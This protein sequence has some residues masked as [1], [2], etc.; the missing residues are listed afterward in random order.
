[1]PYPEPSDPDYCEGSREL[2]KDFD[3]D[4]LWHRCPH[5]KRP[6]AAM[7]KTRRFFPH[8]NN[9]KRARKRDSVHEG[10][11]EFGM[12]SRRRMYGEPVAPVYAEPER[13]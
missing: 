9:I 6:I 4:K 7:G 13:V 2:I 5:C 12:N 3:P 8:V 11:I 1:M 10:L